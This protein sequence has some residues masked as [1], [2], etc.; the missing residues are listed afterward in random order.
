MAY[1]EE[2][3]PPVMRDDMDPEKAALELELLSP[4]SPQLDCMAAVVGWREDP[5][6][7]TRALES[8]KT[9][10]GCMFLMV[11]IDG[12]EAQDQDMVDVFNL[13]RRN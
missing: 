6:L 11:G 2:F 1:Y 7:F 13:V 8:Y 9:A 4:F 5:A 12:D 3:R 10:R